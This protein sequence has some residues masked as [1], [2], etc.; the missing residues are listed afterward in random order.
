MGKGFY[1]SFDAF[2]ALTVMSA[3]LFVVS[4]S[5]EVANDP[6]KSNK[7]AYQKASMSGQDA[8]KLASIEDFYV[9]NSS[10]RQELVDQTV[11]E[12]SDLNRTILDGISLL[13]A[14]RN[15][16][17]ARDS[18]RKYFDER[19]PS[20]YEYKVQVTESGNTTVI[21][22]TSRLPSDP[23]SVSSTPRL[24]SGHKIDKPSEGFQSR[25]RATESES[26]QT[27][28]VNIPMMGSGAPNQRLFLRKKF[29]LNASKIHSA[30]LY[31]SAQW[32]ESN[33]QSNTV[34]VNGQELDIGGSNPEDWEY[35]VEKNS[36]TIGFDKADITSALDKQGWNQFYLEFKNQNN[37]HV[38]IHPGTR[39]KIRYSTD[40][41]TS[42]N[43]KQYLTDIEAEASNANKK[44]GAWITKPLTIPENATVNNVSLHLELRN[45]QDIEDR[46]DV[47]VYLNRDRIY[48]EN[49]SGS[50]TIDLQLKD[51]VEEGTNVLSVY[52]NVRLFNGR[53]NQ[54]SFLGYQ[55]GNPRIY[56]DPEN[57]PGDSSYIYVDVD[58]PT[59]GLQYGKLEVVDSQNIGGSPDNPK[60]FSQSFQER[61]ELLD[62]YLNLAQLDS[63]NVSLEAGSGS[64]ERVF[65]SPRDYA[66]PSKIRIK[67]EMLEQGATNSF[68]VSDSC[69]I[70][71]SILP[72]TGLEKHVMVPSQVGYGGVF[73]NRS[74]AI[75]DANKRLEDLMGRYADATSIENEVLSTGNQPYLWGPASVKLVV[76]D[77]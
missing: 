14:G 36:T 44:G 46:P 30:T 66:T 69:S 38:H 21:Y 48:T 27:K 61:L 23:D 65:S 29:K 18:V 53:I 26:N 6:F 64:L 62:A 34:S 60:L 20:R 50:A 47:Q 55:N 67:P 9:F 24:V 59:T 74:A 31:F 68:R 70:N 77:E 22:R 42:Q 76:W 52:G 2:L 63:R 54:S 28:V 32:G 16:T 13:W 43:E 57:N 8:M 17:Y 5:S 49:V 11:M 19:L 56:S 12:E 4:Q 39:L 37:H 71:C 15:F 40:K 51:R 35:Y 73:E 3:S 25:A 45:I 33:F 75:K 10:F 41:L 1:F 72:E 58:S 7:V